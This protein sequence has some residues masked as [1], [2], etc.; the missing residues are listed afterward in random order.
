MVC[1]GSEAD[2]GVRFAHVR[3]TPLSRHAQRRGSMSAKCQKR[4]SS[5]N[6]VLANAQSWPTR[7]S[8][9]NSAGDIPEPNLRG[10]LINV[11][12]ERCTAT[13]VQ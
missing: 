9:P 2:I 12:Q 3:V 10:L 11:S 1:F 4:S 6:R 7:D 8:L 13:E 5:G